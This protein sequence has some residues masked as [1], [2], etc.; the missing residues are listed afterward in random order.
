MGGGNDANTRVTG[1]VMLGD[2]QGIV[3]GAVIP[4]NQLEIGVGLRQDRGN[5]GG[6]I[7]LAVVDR[8]DQGDRGGHRSYQLWKVSV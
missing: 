7:S 8:D 2:R 4:Q 3:G 1:G 6:Q 5:Q